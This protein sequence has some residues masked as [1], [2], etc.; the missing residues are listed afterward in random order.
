VV[1]VR[2]IVLTSANGTFKEVISMYKEYA[3]GAKMM[4]LLKPSHIKGVSYGEVTRGD[5]CFIAVMV[6]LMMGFLTIAMFFVL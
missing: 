1:C 2:G 6:S 4:D 3:D 5:A